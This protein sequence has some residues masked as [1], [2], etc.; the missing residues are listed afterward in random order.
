M[1]KR[2]QRGFCDESCA[3]GCIEAEKE[4][5][6]EVNELLTVSGSNFTLDRDEDGIRIKVESSSLTDLIFIL[7]TRSQIRLEH[8]RQEIN[9]AILFRHDFSFRSVSDV[10]S[11][12]AQNIAID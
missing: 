1:L 12:L 4:I 6:S 5:A 2:I 11:Y 8:E 10:I 3:S 9:S 7:F